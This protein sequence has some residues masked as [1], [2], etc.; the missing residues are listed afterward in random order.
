MASG[1]MGDRMRSFRF[2][3]AIRFSVVMTGAVAAVAGLS[4]FALRQGLV[5]ELE[6]SD[7][8]VR[9]LAVERHAERLRVGQLEA[10]GV[11]LGRG[12]V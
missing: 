1:W 8:G 5:R 7:A 12:V 3:L 2:L 9:V 6:A 10:L 4:Y 11:D